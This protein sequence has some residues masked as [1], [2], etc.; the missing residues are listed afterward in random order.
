M[1]LRKKTN[2]SYLATSDPVEQFIFSR[3]CSSV[4]LDSKTSSAEMNNLFEAKD[5]SSTRNYILIFWY[6]KKNTSETYRKKN[7]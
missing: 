7:T 2:Y 4:L 3:F 1:K 6:V 5:V